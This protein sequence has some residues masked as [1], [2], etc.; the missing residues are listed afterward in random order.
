MQYA[1]GILLPPVQTLVATLIDDSLRVTAPL[2]V[3]F[4]LPY[5]SP[6]ICRTFSVQVTA[7][8]APFIRWTKGAFSYQF[9]LS[10]DA[11][12]QT[13]LAKACLPVTAA[14]IVVF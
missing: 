10:Q 1:G 14:G 12:V 11:F 5:G 2:E 3:V 13:V 9:L 8:K 4:L 6:D 7:T